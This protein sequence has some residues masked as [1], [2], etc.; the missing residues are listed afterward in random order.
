M[1]NVSFFSKM[2][3]DLVTTGSGVLFQAELGSIFSATI[4]TTIV[5]PPSGM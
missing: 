3:I 5:C 2:H 4:N 1:A